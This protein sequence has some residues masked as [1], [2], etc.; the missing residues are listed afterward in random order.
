[1]KKIELKDLNILLNVA[2]NVLSLSEGSKSSCQKLEKNI[3]L[4]TTII[5]A[6]NAIFQVFID[7]IILPV[8]IMLNLVGYENKILHC[9]IV[10]RSMH[11]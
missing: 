8:I 1:M 6:P 9:T 2:R 7:L 11:I 10:W 3:E 4:W 5:L